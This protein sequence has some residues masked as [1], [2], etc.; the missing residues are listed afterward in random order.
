VSRRR[1]GQALAIAGMAFGLFGLYLLGAAK[2]ISAGDGRLAR[3]LLDFFDPMTATLV[4]SYS[5]MIFGV[6]L[7]ALGVYVLYSEKP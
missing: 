1:L 3:L 2:E 7:G 5:P 4:E 6:L